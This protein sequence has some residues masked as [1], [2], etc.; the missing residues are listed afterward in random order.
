MPSNFYGFFR[1]ETC[2]SQDCSKLLDFEQKQRR[3]D[4]DQEM[5][6]TF[7]EDPD[8]LKKIITGGESLKPKLT[9]QNLMQFL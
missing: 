9:Q 5:L 3:M 8:L 7:N 1:H 2:G 6:K 4:F